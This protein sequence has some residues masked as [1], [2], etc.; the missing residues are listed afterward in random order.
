MKLNR[1]FQPCVK[2]RAVLPFGGVLLMIIVYIGIH[3]GWYKH[4]DDSPLVAGAASVAD[5]GEAAVGG[6]GAHTPAVGPTARCVQPPDKSV[7]TS[8]QPLEKKRAS[9]KNSLHLVGKILS[10]AVERALAVIMSELPEEL[11][12]EHGKTHMKLQTRWG[13]LNWYT[14]MAAGKMQP[15][16]LRTIGKLRDRALYER[17][18]LTKDGVRIFGFAEADLRSIAGTVTDYLQHLLGTEAL[19]QGLYC[20][21][22]PAVFAALVHDEDEHVRVAL[23]YCRACFEAMEKAE[24]LVVNSGYTGKRLASQM[25]RL[26]PSKLR[27]QYCTIRKP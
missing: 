9:S 8:D 13:C 25:V 12:H 21:C 7:C 3:E 26:M 1:W 24:K 17:M 20:R 14:D 16:L 4:V 27:F 23:E 11:E 2:T 18:G 15:V 10:N 22:L 19:Y 6:G 5:D